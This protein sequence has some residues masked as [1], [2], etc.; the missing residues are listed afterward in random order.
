M[1]P[2]A[3]APDAGGP[4]VAMD[5]LWPREE[6]AARCERLYGCC[7]STELTGAGFD[8]QAECVTTIG[9]G[10]SLLSQIFAQRIAAGTLEYRPELAGACLARLEALTCDEVSMQRFFLAS[11]SLG[12]VYCIEAV[13]GLVAAGQACDDDLACTSRY[14]IAEGLAGA[15][16]CGQR[17][18]LGEP[19]HGGCVGDLTCAGSTATT[20]GSCT[21]K[22]GVGGTC[23]TSPDCQVGLVCLQPA[24]Q[25]KVPDQPVCDGL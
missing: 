14:C 3:L 15:G 23:V 10:L 11:T 20:A 18:G 25:C 24:G 5:D 21:M 4:P 19:C 12:S 6:A 1:G 17:P 8:S 16:T 9:D 2:D 22:S 13:Q 7:T